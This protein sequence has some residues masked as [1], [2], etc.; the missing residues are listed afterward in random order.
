MTVRQILWGKWRFAPNAI[1]FVCVLFFS[2][3]GYAAKMFFGTGESITRIEPVKLRGPNGEQLW[4]G[5]KTTRES[6]ILPYTL[7]DDGYVLLISNET[8]RYFNLPPP[9]KVE[10]FQQTGLLPKPFPPY[11]IPWHE[12]AFGYAAWL[13]LGMLPFVFWIGRVW[14]RRRSQAGKAAFSDVFR[15][16]R[17]GGNDLPAPPLPVLPKVLTHGKLKFLAWFIAASV[18]V[19]IGVM[20]LRTHAELAYAVLGL[21]GIPALFLLAQLVRR[22][23]GYLR[24]D[25]QGLVVKT[26]IRNERT[27]LWDSVAG[28]AVVTKNGS[29]RVTWS[30]NLQAQELQQG[31]SF[32]HAKPGATPSLPDN[33]GLEADALA[34]LLAAVH[35]VRLRQIHLPGPVADLV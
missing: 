12:Y 8:G 9:D 35:L 27:V 7:R 11:Q 33:Y 1:L 16:V 13:T 14:R 26:P 29:D 28:F 19:A 23:P 2:S 5:H 3:S 25:Q 20:L 22:Q 10:I 15:N 18:F 32:W 21:F 6:F 34:H 30:W 4:I 31:P 17:A 24:I